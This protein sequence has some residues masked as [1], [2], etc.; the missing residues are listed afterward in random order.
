MMPAVLP[1][2]PRADGSH[3]RVAIFIVNNSRKQWSGS[4][5]TCR[6]V[7]HTTQQRVAALPCPGRSAA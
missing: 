4:D 6:L 2:A 1:I 7:L 3:V 5:H